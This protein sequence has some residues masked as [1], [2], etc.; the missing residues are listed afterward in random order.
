MGEEA[1]KSRY[2][3]ALGMCAGIAVGAG[4]VQ[5]LHAQT[6]PPVYMV[7]I[8]EVSD[9]EG[10][11]KE[12]LPRAQK[13]IKDHGGV[14][15]AAGAGTQVAGGLPNGRVVILRWASMEALLGWRNSPEYQAAL[16]MGEKYAKY[17]I[18][19]VNGVSQ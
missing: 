15:I 8:N 14:Y 12:Y 11:A 7:A 17:N 18:I 10:Y 9:Q 19:A 3:V 2:A 16:K 4:A 13:A 1:V 5:V 6:K